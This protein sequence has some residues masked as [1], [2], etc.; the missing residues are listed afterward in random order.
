MLGINYSL[1]GNG[2]GGGNRRP[3]VRLILI[4][5]P[6]LVGGSDGGLTLFCSLWLLL[7]VEFSDFFLFSLLFDLL[8][9]LL[10]LLELL[11]L[12]IFSLILLV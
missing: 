10:E 5:R 3:N 12:L 9:K 8:F 4:L 1:K 7:L 11:L 6:R 2:V